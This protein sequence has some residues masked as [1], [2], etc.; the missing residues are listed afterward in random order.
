M[1]ATAPVP[2]SAAPVPSTCERCGGFH[3]DAAVLLRGKRLC[4]ACGER[5]LREI[6]S[7]RLWPL[8]YLWVVGVLLGGAVAAVLAALNWRRLGEAERSRNAW[9]YAGLGVAGTTAIVALQKA[10][11]SLNVLF[12][13]AVT[14]LAVNGFE[15]PWRTH[16]EQGGQ[17]A[18]RVLPILITLAVVVA[19]GVIYAAIEFALGEE[20]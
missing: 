17:V 18:N 13:I 16:K 6:R 4:A 15:V 9:I 5:V 20:V 1:N 2:Q 7:A 10:P 8:G 11:A 12:S 19:V 3:G 14:K